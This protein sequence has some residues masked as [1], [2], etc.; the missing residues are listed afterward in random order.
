M[1]YSYLLLS[2]I[3]LSS[4]SAQ[5]AG[6][7]PQSNGFQAQRA[8][9]PGA[10]PKIKK[11]SRIDAAQ[12]QTITISGSGFGTMSAYNGDSAYL[13]ILDLTGKWSAGYVSS[14]QTDSVYLDV[15]GWTDNTITIAGFTG[16]YGQSNW[17]LNKGDKLEVNVWNAQ[18]GSGPGTKDARVR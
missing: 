5:T 18:T 8:G 4:C 6:S 11:I 12:Y 17:T 13:Q 14:S 1:R 2:A 15:T 7:L 9:A 10:K 16:E 3:V